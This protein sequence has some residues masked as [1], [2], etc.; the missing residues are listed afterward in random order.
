MLNDIN[1]RVYNMKKFTSKILRGIA[2]LIT[3][4][5]GVLIIKTNNDDMLIIIYLLSITLMMFCFSLFLEWISY[6]NQDS[7]TYCSTKDVKLIMDIAGII[8]LST[9]FEFVDSNMKLMLFLISSLLAIIS[10]YMIR[11]KALK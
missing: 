8:Q 4:L 10:L 11:K 7:D 3:N 5:I 2:I 6:K 1:I 9:I